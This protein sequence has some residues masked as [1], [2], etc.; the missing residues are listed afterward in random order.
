MLKPVGK[1]GFVKRDSKVK[2]GEEMKS[3]SDMQ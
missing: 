3:F 1:P 2:R